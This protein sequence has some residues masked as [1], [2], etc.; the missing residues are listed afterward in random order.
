MHLG[1]LFR[2]EQYFL[3]KKPAASD[4]VVLGLLAAVLKVVTMMDALTVPIQLP[5]HKLDAA[6][7]RMSRQHSIAEVSED[8]VVAG[9]TA[10]FEPRGGFHSGHILQ[11]LRGDVLDAIQGILCLGRVHIRPPIEHAALAGDSAETP[12]FPADGQVLVLDALRFEASVY[13][14]DFE[15]FEVPELR[16]VGLIVHFEIPLV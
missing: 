2:L 14:A 5:R 1:E 12:F 7:G 16:H 10:D 3:G 6:L 15:F 9:E 4:E 8:T 11:R 13:Q